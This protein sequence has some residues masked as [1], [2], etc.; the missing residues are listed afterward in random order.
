MKDYKYPTNLRSLRADN[1]TNRL[2]KSKMKHTK[3]KRFNLPD[4]DE[5]QENVYVEEDHVDICETRYLAMITDISF[6]KSKKSKYEDIVNIEYSYW[7][8]ETQSIIQGKASYEDIYTSGKHRFQAFCRVF[9]AIEYNK[10]RLETILGSM[11]MVEYH[12]NTGKILRKPSRDERRAY[13]RIM[14]EFSNL[15]VSKEITD[16]PDMIE[17]YWICN[18]FDPTQK[19][20]DDFYGIITNIKEKM[21]AEEKEHI[22]TVMVF[23]DGEKSNYNFYTNGE[24]NYKYKYLNDLCNGSVNEESIEE[25]KY[26]GVKVRLYKSKKS[27]N[28]YINEITEEFFDSDIQKTQIDMFGNYWLNIITDKN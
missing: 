24:S 8:S 18:V 17:D 12:L 16:I 6:E 28:I 4:F 26:T 9:G 11:C 21:G 20:N 23:I 3:L 5:F 19:Y 2:G 7:D 1:E 13:D 15:K 27:D 10:L 22:V 14:R 25:L